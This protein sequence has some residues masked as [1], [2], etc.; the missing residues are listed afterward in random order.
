MMGFPDQYPT[1]TLEVGARV[2]GEVTFE[3]DDSSVM[4]TS[5]GAAKKEHI[6]A[7]WFKTWIQDNVE[8]PMVVQ[9]R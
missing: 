8:R 1:G 7:E 9:E 3:I 5:Q 2:G 4:G 6:S